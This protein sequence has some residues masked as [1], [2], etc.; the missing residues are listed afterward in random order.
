M[1]NHAGHRL[2]PIMHVARILSRG[3]GR[4]VPLGKTHLPETLAAPHTTLQSGGHNTWQGRILSRGWS[5]SP[6][7][8][9]LSLRHTQSCHQPF[10][11]TWTGRMAFTS[12]GLPGT[13]LSFLQEIK[14]EVA[15]FFPQL[16]MPDVLRLIFLPARGHS[17]VTLPPCPCRLWPL[18]CDMFTEKFLKTTTLNPLQMPVLMGHVE[19]LCHE[20]FSKNQGVGTP[21][22]RTPQVL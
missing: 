2:H 10:W 20:N 12:W 19:F 9:T 7:L 5:R 11:A 17:D 14:I 1:Q 3:T 15:F 18:D 16:G 13:F 21:L 22:A 8:C 6:G 4:E